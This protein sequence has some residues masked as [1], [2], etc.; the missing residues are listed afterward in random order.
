MFPGSRL[1]A[2][3]EHIF[4]LFFCFNNFRQ[5]SPFFQW[6]FLFVER[7]YAKLYAFCA[8][9]AVATRAFIGLSCGKSEIGLV[10]FFQTLTGP[11]RKVRTVS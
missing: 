11:N 2:K 7:L 8:L 6:P 1:Y 4:I 10:R 5:I 9:A 3:S